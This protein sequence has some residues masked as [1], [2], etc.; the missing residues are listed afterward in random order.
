MIKLIIIGSG[1]VT[2]TFLY[3]IIDYLVYRTKRKNK[4][5]L[6]WKKSYD[7]MGILDELNQSQHNTI[8]GCVFENLGGKPK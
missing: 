6:F 2:F 3:L 7:K 5:K 8:F 1:L 4:N